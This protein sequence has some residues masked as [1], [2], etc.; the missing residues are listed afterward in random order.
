MGELMSLSG[1]L[2]S[3]IALL[4]VVVARMSFVIFFLP[5]IGEQTI[6]AQAR[7][8]VLLAISFALATTG[9]IDQP[10]PGYAA[11]G[12]TL[13]GEATIGF[14]LGVTLRVV[15]WMLSIAGTVISQSIGLSQLLGVAMEHESQ[16]MVGN[17]LSMAGA[18]LLLSADFHL[19]AIASLLRMYGD[20]P[21]GAVGAL[22][23]GRLTKK[24]AWLRAKANG[25][26]LLSRLFGGAR[27]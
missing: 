11:Y 22:D 23:Q 3:W 10:P 14:C 27:S 25:E 5:G 12:A 20:I 17:M 6:P 2:A 13:I 16:A 1:P 24:A 7:L 15:I 9:V 21:V 18:A 4:L 26:G 8:L 19:N